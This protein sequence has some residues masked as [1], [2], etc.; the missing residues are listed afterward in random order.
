MS[1]ISER[2]SIKENGGFTLVELIVTILILGILAAVAV[3]SLVGYIDKAKEQAAMSDAHTILVGLQSLAIMDGIDNAG[4]TV[5]G[6]RNNGY[7]AH[8]LPGDNS[9][10][11]GCDLSDKGI[12][13]LVKLTGIEEEKI[14]HPDLNSPQNT[15]GMDSIIVKDGVIE[16]FYYLRDGYRV[17]YSNGD[18][19]CEKVS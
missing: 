1:Q 15:L 2:K 6:A 5:D 18:F 16:G 9:A 7:F 11:T 12:A 4:N 13:A 10:D 17:A 3:P 8:V 14:K 19:S